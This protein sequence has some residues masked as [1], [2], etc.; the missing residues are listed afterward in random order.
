M[1]A[2]FDNTDTTNAFYFALNHEVTAI[3]NVNTGYF[4][5]M[6]AIKRLPS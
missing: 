5:I 1:L 4:A 3:H 2:N 6:R